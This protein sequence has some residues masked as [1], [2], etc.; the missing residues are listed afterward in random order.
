MS[1]SNLSQSIA[2]LLLLLLSAYLLHRAFSYSN[3]WRGMDF[4]Q[5]WAVGQAVSTMHVDNI[6]SNLDRTRIGTEMA[7]RAAVDPKASRHK[8]VAKRRLVLETYSSPFLYT[9]LGLLRFRTY[10]T[11]FQIYRIFSL[12]CGLLAILLF[13]RLLSYSTLQTLAV[14]VIFTGWFEPFFSELRVLNVNLLQLMLL[15]ILCWMLGKQCSE[16][17]DVAIGFLIGFIVVFK[18][19]TLFVGALLFAWYV[20]RGLLAKGLR[21]VVGAFVSML[22]FGAIS[23]WFFGSIYPWLDWTRALFALPDEIITPMHS[24]YSLT[25]MIAYLTGIDLSPFLLP[26][27]FVFSIAFLWIICRHYRTTD[28]R[29]SAPEVEKDIM[30]VGLGCLIYLVAARLVWLHYYLLSVPSILVLLYYH[31]ISPSKESRSQNPRRLLLALAIALL[32]LNPLL[33]ILRVKTDYEA[34]VMSI[35]GVLVLFYLT[36]SELWQWRTVDD[37]SFKRPADHSSVGSRP[38]VVTGREEP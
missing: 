14:I 5:F 8:S 29:H 12:L 26:L 28:A 2:T 16:W 27:L 7:R 33:T 38:N 6:Y 3:Q 10:E 36:L 22:F 31:V 30:I 23:S 4:Y 32:S 25:M 35:S 13:C 11:A 34:A 21:M 24:N 17:W 37:G 20:F 1:R 19:N 15:A 9:L 18:P